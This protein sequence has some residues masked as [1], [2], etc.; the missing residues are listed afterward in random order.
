MKEAR[1][2]ARDVGVAVDHA[3]IAGFSSDAR[4]EHNDS[5]IIFQRAL[6]DDDDDE[7]VYAEIPI[8]RFCCYD[9][10]ERFVISRNTCLVEFFDG[11][12]DEMDGL[13]RISIEF[14]LNDH[15]FEEVRSI[16]RRIFRGHEAYRE[17]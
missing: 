5:A 1:F 6:E 11:S 17:E 2:V 7:G 16:L 4:I 13:K 14:D 15:K 8:Q 3:L 12:I 9:G 10:I